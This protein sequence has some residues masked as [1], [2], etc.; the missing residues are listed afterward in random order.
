[1]GIIL[2]HL[3]KK[4]LY[5]DGSSFNLFADLN[6][7]IENGKVSTFIG[8]KGCGKSLVLKII[9]G[10]KKPTGGSVRFGTDG[11]DL[12]SI[13]YY[14]PKRTVHTDPA[15]SLEE[16]IAAVLSADSPYNPENVLSAFGLAYLRDT[17]PFYLTGYLRIKFDLC[18]ILA[19]NPSVIILDEAFNELDSYSRTAI[20]HECA[21][22][23]RES[24]KTVILATNDVTEAITLSDTVYVLNGRSG[25]NYRRIDVNLDRDRP[26]SASWIRLQQAIFAELSFRK[27]VYEYAKK[28]NC[29]EYNKCGREPGGE[30]ANEL[31]VC[32]ASTE[33][34]LDG[35]HGGTNAGRTCWVVAANACACG[36][37]DRQQCASCDFYKIV[38]RESTDFHQ[39]NTLLVFLN[40]RGEYEKKK[41]RKLLENLLDPDIVTQAL[42]DIESLKRGGEKR[43]TAL[44]SDIRNFSVISEKLSDTELFNFINEYLS[45]M[46]QAIKEEKGTIDKYIGD[47]VVAI[48]GAPVEYSDTGHHA[49]RA[50]LTM[51]RKLEGMKAYWKCNNLYC[52]EVWDLSVRIG[53]NTG[54]AKLGFIGTEMH[55]AYTMMG[56]TVNVAQW[57]ETSC[58]QFSVSLLLT[59]ETKKELPDGISVQPLGNVK[60]KTGTREIPVY[61]IAF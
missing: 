5:P 50:A 48:F 57:M 32:P 41:Y 28:I 22:V 31:G 12:Q 6:L 21:R 33:K 46:T 38:E 10:I 29:W 44:F 61:T 25:G 56:E 58:K 59:E 60:T 2:E 7:E 34:K 30:R 49:V 23:L 54:T 35:I 27:P 11:Q 26:D 19:R 43:I 40:N 14:S 4:Y 15:I 16:N 52:P 55:A 9:A 37:Q 51:L 20:D 13:I 8:P 36:Q 42:T 47:A 53:L 17:R 18:M 45:I 24:G 3:Q 39:L 1:M